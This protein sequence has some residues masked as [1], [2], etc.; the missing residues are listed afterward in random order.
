M[1]HTTISPLWPTTRVERSHV[2]RGARTPTTVGGVAFEDSSPLF[3]A[4]SRTAAGRDRGRSRILGKI[5]EAKS[6]ARVALDLGIECAT[7]GAR[8]RFAATRRAQSHTV[9]A[10]ALAL[11]D[12]VRFRNGRGGGT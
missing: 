10:A 9:P 11:L 4:Q 3:T 6:L 1:W 5:L 12:E 2:R 7:L 8:G